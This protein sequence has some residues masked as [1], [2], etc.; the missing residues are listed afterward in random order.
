MT[1]MPVQH[2]QVQDLNLAFIDAGEGQPLIFIHGNY[3]SR[4]WFLNQLHDPPE[5]WRYIALDMPNFGESDP[6]PGDISIQAYAEAVVA[7][8]DTLELERFAVLGHSLGGSV[9]QHIAVNNP[10]R[11]THMILL[12]SAGPAGHYT[13][14]DHLGLLEK[15]KGNRDLLGR[16]LAGTVPTNRPDWFEWLIDDAVAMQQHAYTGNAIALMHSDLSDL[17]HNYP[18]PVLVIRGELDLPHLITDEIARLT[19][20]SY[21]NGRLLN[22]QGVGHA[23]QLE[24]PVRFNTT[25]ERFLKGA[26]MD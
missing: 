6:L 19:A 9:A 21:P 7:F 2:V 26:D 8:A 17:T 1:D 20:D 12:A 13:S 16:A 15:F 3:S 25:L 24:D 22:Y 11:V 14:D 18:G 5:G 4:R 10:E 23:P